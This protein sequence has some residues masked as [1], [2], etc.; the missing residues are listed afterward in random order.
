M[1]ISGCRGAGIKLS[2]FVTGVHMTNLHIHSVNTTGIEMR[3]GN[4]VTIRNCLIEDVEGS[5]ILMG[6]GS[7]NN[8]VE[9]NTIRNFGDRGVLVGSDNTEVQY[10]DT[11]FA[12]KT[13]GGSWHDAVNC[14]IRNNIIAHGGNAGLA[15]YSARDIVAVQNTVIDVG[16]AAQGA[17]LLDLSPKQL[18]NTYEVQLPNENITLENN[19]ITLANSGLPMIEA[20]IL[21]QAIA[22]RPLPAIFPTNSSGNCSSQENENR[23]LSAV[24]DHGTESVTA[25]DRRKLVSPPLR[26]SDG[27]CSQFPADNAWHLD[28]TDLPV[29]PDSHSIRT[30]INAGGNLHPDFGGGQTI[31]DSNK[32]P[33]FVPYG[34]PINTVN[35]ASL[36]GEPPQPLVP[37]T[38]GPNGYP[39]ECDYPLDYPFPVNASIEGSFLN[40][41]DSI[42]PGDRHCLVIDNSSCILYE[43]WR[44]FSPGTT[45]QGWV[46]DIAVKFDLGSNGLRPLGFTSSDAAGLP[47]AP[48]LVQFDEVINKGKINHAMRFT[49]PNSRAAYAFPATHYAPAGDTGSDSP[50]MGMRVRLNASFD[51]TQLARAARVFCV[52]LKTYGGIFADNGSPWYFSGE[53]TEK[54]LP[55]L[56][57]LEDIT[58]IPASMID[59]L[60]TGCLCLDPSC[61]ITECANGIYDPTALPTDA[62]VD[63]YS[64]INFNHNFYYRMDGGTGRYVDRKTGYLGVGYDGP[65]SGWQAYTNGDTSSLEINPLVDYTSYHLLLDS[66]AIRNVPLLPTASLDIYG[67]K[68]NV[69]GGKVNAGVLFANYTPAPSFSPTLRPTYVPSSQPTGR[70]TFAPSSLPTKFPTPFST[71]VPTTSSP[72]RNPDWTTLLFQSGQFINYVPYNYSYDTGISSLYSDA[73]YRNFN[74]EFISSR[75]YRNLD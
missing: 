16:I 3:N 71:I 23:L 9:F 60:D 14:T 8:V 26:N 1:D 5:G 49:G 35:T 50:W 58:K 34:I 7:K 30:L 27:T 47:V 69:V 42:C 20:R 52:A 4:N 67:G 54:W 66:P 17:I 33:F 38:V 11:E 74:G 46:V 6:G 61:T 63:S 57:E 37:L 41:P 15:F 75:Q 70:P 31:L 25:A 2:T 13:P 56:S 64:T 53:A 22:N 68:V 72:T 39:S 19:V 62:A 51:C 65:L 29:H 36:G 55:Y 45:G 59:I 73:S 18:N 32:R 44:S 48:G 43:S 24:S 10:M 12:T 21:Q 40:C 28:V